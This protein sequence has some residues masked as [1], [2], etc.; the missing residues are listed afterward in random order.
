MR[1]ICEPWL[2]TAE[3]WVLIH[4]LGRWEYVKDVAKRRR[5]PEEGKEVEDSS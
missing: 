2:P 4:N 3:E 5:S 1:R